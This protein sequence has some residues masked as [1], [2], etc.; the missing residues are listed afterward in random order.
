MLF[1]W[2][3]RRAFAADM[4]R[5][6]A[7]WGSLEIA[8]KQACKSSRLLASVRSKDILLFHWSLLALNRLVPL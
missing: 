7:D 4:G 3:D 8:Y 5:L 6:G 2:D 1:A